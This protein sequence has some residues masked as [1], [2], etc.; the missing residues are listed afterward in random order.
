MSAEQDALAF[1]SRSTWAPSELD[2]PLQIIRDLLD[3]ID[4][5]V[6]AKLED[7]T[8]EAK[9]DAKT[10]SD[11]ENS[12]LV[13]MITAD[14]NLLC[15]FVLKLFKARR[16]R[17]HEMVELIEK[18]EDPDSGRSLTRGLTRKTHLAVA[19]ALL[20]RHALAID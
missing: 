9:A 11:E 15:A 2:D 14:Q 12:K 7:A 1:L 5:V 18:T 17:V 13:D 4:A 16:I 6:E 8:K 10:A 20:T 19:E 3:G